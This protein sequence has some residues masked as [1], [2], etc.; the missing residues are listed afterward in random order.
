LKFL[1]NHLVGDW[2]QSPSDVRHDE[3][4]GAEEHR[5]QFDRPWEWSNCFLDSREVFH[6]LHQVL[7]LAGVNPKKSLAEHWIAQSLALQII[8]I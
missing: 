6:Q 5:S 2:R 3:Q 8:D 4:E 1:I 7:S